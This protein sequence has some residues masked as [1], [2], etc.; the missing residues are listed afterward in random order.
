MRGPRPK[1]WTRSPTVLG[2]LGLVTQPLCA[3]TV[4]FRRLIPM[5]WAW[6][7][8]EHFTPDGNGAGVTSCSSLGRCW[9]EAR[10]FMLQWEYKS[11]KSQGPAQRNLSTFV[12]R[13]EAAGRE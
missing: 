7:L 11:H 1:H 9:E 8:P 10:T 5:P 12:L 3:W 2:D 13:P 6:A 4:V